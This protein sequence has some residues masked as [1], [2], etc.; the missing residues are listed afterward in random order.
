[1]LHNVN[2]PPDPEARQAAD[3]FV[4]RLAEHGL[5]AEDVADN[6]A[7]MLRQLDE[8]AIVA[9]NAG[10]Y[11]RSKVVRVAYVNVGR[12]AKQFPVL[13]VS[14]LATLKNTDYSSWSA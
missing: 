10:Q 6:F 12:V 7:A 13:T 9:W 3:F 11:A 5:Q 2:P 14:L 4:R 1:M 8:I